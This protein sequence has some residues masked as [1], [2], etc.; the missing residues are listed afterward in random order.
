MPA[1]CP[2]HA[3]VMPAP[4]PRHLPVPPGARS[5]A[6]PGARFRW[7]RLRVHRAGRAW[8][9]STALESPGPDLSKPGAEPCAARHQHRRDPLGS[10]GAGQAPKAPTGGT[11][12]GRGRGAGCKPLFGLGRADVARVPV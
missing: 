4:R 2:R 9:S 12:Y 1:P 11:G 10:G 7:R 6:F 8:S 3:R 5:P